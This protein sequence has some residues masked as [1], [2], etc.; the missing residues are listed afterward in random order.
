MTSRRTRVF[1]FALL[2]GA[3]V[4]FYTATYDVRSITD[5]DLNSLQTR[6]LALHGDADLTRYEPNPKALWVDWHGGKYSIYGVGV[7]LP[8]VP[9]YAVLARMEVSDRTLQAAAAIPYVAAAVIVLYRVL[10]ELFSRVNAT[11]GAVLFA[12]GTTMWPVAS[13]AFYQNAV[14]ALFQAMGLWGLFSKNDRGPILAGLGFG[15]ATMVRPIS[16]IP[17][18]FVG[19]FYL[20][21]E[22]RS[23]IRYGLGAML[24][25]LV[26]LVQNRWIWGGWLTGGYSHNIA[27]YQG[28]VPHALWGLMFGWWRGLLVYS[29]FLIAGFV[30]MVVASRRR[31][32]FLESRLVLLGAIVIGTILLYARFT[33]WHGGLNQFGYRYLLDAVPF[34]IVL[35]V[36]ALDRLPRL[37]LSFLALGALSVLTM[38]FGSEPNRYSWDFT[39]LATRLVDTSIGQAWTVAV[40]HPVGNLVRAV[41]VAAV[42]YLFFVASRFLSPAGVDA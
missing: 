41:G 9:L 11:I 34:L 13:M 14:T 16:A 1:V 3:L 30:G 37:R 5:A 27:G 21:K 2:F 40:N 15:L 29:P 31:A 12:F 7:S 17:L 6:A 42:T 22:R 4:A 19:V 32:G 8:A 35:T 38:I 28:D 18:V 25:I 20:L 36:Y 33:T 26:I 10:L 24:P 39:Y 23:V